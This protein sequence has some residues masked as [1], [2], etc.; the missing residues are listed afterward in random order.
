ME[1]RNLKGYL[2]WGNDLVRTNV[3]MEL[4]ISGSPAYYPLIT[5]GVNWYEAMGE[6]EILL[7]DT[8]ELVFV[9]S[10]MEGKRKDRYSMALP[11]LPRRPAKA[12][13]L[14]IRLEFESDKKCRIHVKDLGFGELY[15]SSGL[16]WEET[17][18]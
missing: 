13:R 7:D 1:E 15:P 12:T 3:G 17:I 4:L 8:R 14:H 11:G 18:A 6:C 10:D 9:V 16:T 5:A 2:Y